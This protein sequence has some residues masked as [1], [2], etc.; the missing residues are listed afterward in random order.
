MVS[1]PGNSRGPRDVHA[2]FAGRLRIPD[3]WWRNGFGDDRVDGTALTLGLGRRD[4][5]YVGARRWAVQS[6]TGGGER[7]AGMDD[8]LHDDDRGRD[9]HDD[10]DCHPEREPVA[11]RAGGMAGRRAGGTNRRQTGGRQRCAHPGRLLLGRQRRG[12]GREAE[13]DGRRRSEIDDGRVPGPGETGVLVANLL[14]RVDGER[15]AGG[16]RRHGKEVH[17][18]KEA[19]VVT[20]SI[21]GGEDGAVRK[22]ID[23]RPAAGREGQLRA[24]HRVEARKEMARVRLAVGDVGIG[25]LEA[26]DQIR[27]I[28]RLRRLKRLA[29]SE[30]AERCA[31]DLCI[32]RRH[33][34]IGRV[35]EAQVERRSRRAGDCRR[36][37]VAVEDG[38]ARRKPLERPEVEQLAESGLG[39]HE[40]DVML[41]GRHRCHEAVG[42]GRLGRAAGPTGNRL[43]DR[44]QVD[45]LRGIANPEGCRDLGGGIQRAGVIGGLSDR[46]GEGDQPMSRSRDVLRRRCIDRLRPG[47][48]GHDG[49]EVRAAQPTIRRCRSSGTA[50]LRG[51]F[52]HLA[53]GKHHRRY[54]GSNRIHPST[55]YQRTDNK[56]EQ[57]R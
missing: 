17:G 11:W 15:P 52:D 5:L 25:G 34:A 19:V 45:G 10:E 47:D 55:E 3:Q 2:G 40:V 26:E 8:A 50:R 16:R 29:R 21:G 36:A 28:G 20:G 23:R 46:K 37:R 57:Q 56:E 9:E 51:R 53:R 6:W 54:G 13:R 35:G 22:T 44:G 4:G 7:P 39:E 42:A 14:S 33:E 32:V 24:G 12:Y 31:G 43:V 1:S 18:V 48:P 27:L 30:V 49:G 38:R 41:S